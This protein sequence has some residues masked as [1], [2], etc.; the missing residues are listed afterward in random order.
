MRQVVFALIVALHAAYA[1][2]MSK[3]AC[4][5]K[6]ASTA[7]SNETGISIVNGR[8]A[9]ECAW[10][11]Q[12]G[13]W[14]SGVTRGYPWCGGTLISKEWVLTAAH[15]VSKPN[16]DVV[17]GDWKVT[18]ISKKQQRRKAL[19]VYR[20]PKYRSRSE[21]YDFALVRIEPADFNSCIG[22]ACLPVKNEPLPKGTK[23]WIT[24]WGDT[25]DGGSQSKTLQEVEVK[26][27]SNADC[28]NKFGYSKKDIDETMICAQGRT[29]KGAVTDACN[30]DSG[31][32]LVCESG[33]K[34][35]LFGATSWGDGCANKKYPGVWARV[36]FVM[37]WIDGI[38]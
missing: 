19:K 31:G 3:L 2:R 20:H 6:G 13:L 16:F 33:G 14:S 38:I 7:S 25:K 10:K 35:T 28:V 32:P 23:C 5:L 30:G 27:I 26:I 9:S 29:S 24:G 11:W 36:P 8:P 15:C 17:L 1:A 22:T 21:S 34:W 12:V 4:G 37:D 18:K